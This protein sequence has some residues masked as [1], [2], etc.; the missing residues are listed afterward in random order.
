MPLTS[1]PDAASLYAKMRED[2]AENLAKLAAKTAPA[3]E[4]EPSPEPPTTPTE[5]A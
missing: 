1:H 4:A 5:E 2:R 3:P